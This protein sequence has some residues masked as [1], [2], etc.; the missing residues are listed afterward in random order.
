M[1]QVLRRLREEDNALLV[2]EGGVDNIGE[3]TRGRVGR[4]PQDAIRVL[5]AQD[6]ASLL[7]ASV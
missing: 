4:C 7:D 3:L 6:G 5:D 2:N 1:P